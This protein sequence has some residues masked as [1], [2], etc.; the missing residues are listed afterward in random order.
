MFLS[1]Q[2]K[3]KIKI[4]NTH[5]IAVMAGQVSNTNCAKQEKI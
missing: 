1:D 3:K 4:L 2:S 5:W